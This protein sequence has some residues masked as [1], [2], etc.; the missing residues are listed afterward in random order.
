MVERQNMG[1]VW[2]CATV[3]Y[4]FKLYLQNQNGCVCG[5]DIEAI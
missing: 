2:A 4:K 1:K 5:M 3:R